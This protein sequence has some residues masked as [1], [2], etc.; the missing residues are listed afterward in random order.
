[1]PVYSQIYQG[2]ERREES[3]EVFDKIAKI[4]GKA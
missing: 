1:M 3:D 2:D 4:K